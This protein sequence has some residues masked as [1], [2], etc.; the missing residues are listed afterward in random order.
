MKANKFSLGL[1]VPPEAND[2]YYREGLAMILLS[3]N[4]LRSRLAFYMAANAVLSGKD[5]SMLFSLKGLK[6]IQKPERSARRSYSR[7]A[8][9]GRRRF[10][11]PITLPQLPI[12]SD[13]RVFMRMLKQN[14]LNP[15]PRIY[16]MV[17]EV[18]LER[19]PGLEEVYDWA[20]EVGVKMVPCQSSMEHDHVRSS[21]LRENVFPPTC[22]AAFLREA[23]CSRLIFL[24]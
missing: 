17:A 13:Q 4:A 20:V 1:L 8:G 21:R 6:S 22:A 3:E 5:V 11:N 19:V 12:N 15:L 23:A 2:H 14:G 9:Q 16:E 10:S 24:V 7:Q 18:G